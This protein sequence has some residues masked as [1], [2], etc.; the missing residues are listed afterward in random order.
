MLLSRDRMGRSGSFQWIPV[1][2]RPVATPEIQ[3]SHAQGRGQ[4][5][6]TGSAGKLRPEIWAIKMNTGGG[7]KSALGRFP[8][9]ACCAKWPP[10]EGRPHQRKLRCRGG[11]LSSMEDHIPHPTSEGHPLPHGHSGSPDGTVSPERV[12]SN[13]KA[14]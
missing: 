3:Q 6:P 7:Q 11:D 14:Q 8:F 9:R 13:S 12:H 10:R 5:L 1:T 2:C 4:P